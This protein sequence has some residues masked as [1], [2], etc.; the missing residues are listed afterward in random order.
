MT[1]GRS[2]RFCLS[3][4]RGC[5]R[6]KGDKDKGPAKQRVRDDSAKP[7][8]SEVKASGGTSEGK[9]GSRGAADGGNRNGNRSGLGIP[10]A[11]RG[12]GS[13]GQAASVLPATPLTSTITVRSIELEK[14][15]YPTS[16]RL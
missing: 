15:G 11:S 8:I 10:S 3:V 16:P 2:K 9:A 12:K 6:F 1:S 13:F 14:P 4:C 7:Q 5:G